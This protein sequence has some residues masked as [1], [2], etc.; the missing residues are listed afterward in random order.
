MLRRW[1]SATVSICTKSY[2][3]AGIVNL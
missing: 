1:Y 2:A 3:M